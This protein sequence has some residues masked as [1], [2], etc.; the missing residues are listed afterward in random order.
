MAINKLNEK[1]I[2]AGLE[3]TKEIL[4]IELLES[5]A[6]TNDVAKEILHKQPEQVTL[7]ATNKQTAGKGR[8][9]KSFYS[10]LKHG[11]YFTLAF[12]P[13]VTKIE[14]IPLYT[15]LAATALIQV[16]NQYIKEPLKIKWVNDIFYQGKK[17]IGILSETVAIENEE[18]PGVVVGIGINFAGNFNHTDKRTQT[19]AGTLFGEKVPQTF[20]QNEV[21]SA[22]I[23]QF[24]DY[25]KTIDDKTFMPIYEKYL[26][27]IGNDVYYTMKEQ[28]HRGII[29]GIDGNG[30][31]LVLKSD[32]SI[33]TLYGQ[34]VH[35]GSEQFIDETTKNRL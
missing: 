9:G 35:F 23:N 34:E 2:Q 1:E 30:H 11:L 18:L 15:I 10:N 5:V 24:Y 33:E 25:H 20:N 4:N 31:L 19:V 21:L 26:L 28:K 6:S 7:V 3:E 14:D 27:G 32:Q 22:F 8:G 12:R 29:Q 17:I 16:L 13:N